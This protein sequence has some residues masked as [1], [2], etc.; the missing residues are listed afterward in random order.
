MFVAALL[1]KIKNILP[2]KDPWPLLLLLLQDYKILM[3][4]CW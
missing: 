1:E 2:I 3:G 4:K